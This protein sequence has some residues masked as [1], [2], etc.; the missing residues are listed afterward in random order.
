VS[1][2][3]FK[4]PAKIRVHATYG[5]RPFQASLTRTIPI[6][7]A[8]GTEGLSGPTQTFAPD[9]ITNTPAFI[10]FNIP[11]FAKRVRF[12][13]LTIGSTTLQVSFS[14]TQLKGSFV[15]SSYGTH[16]VPMG[17]E[18]PVEISPLDTFIEISNPGPNPILSLA[19]VFELGV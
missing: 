4:N 6:C 16:T 14:Q 8:A 13:R 11:A 7:F 17:S 10:R 18:G 12:P 19:A 9:P 5:R 1:L 15:I 3:Q 2:N